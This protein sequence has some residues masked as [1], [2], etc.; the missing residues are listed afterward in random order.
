MATRRETSLIRLPEDEAARI[1]RRAIEDALSEM[2]G[3]A[4]QYAAEAVPMR[5]PISI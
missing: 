4:R 3:L 5:R 2:Q 1:V